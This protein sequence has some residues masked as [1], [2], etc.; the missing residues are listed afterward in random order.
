MNDAKQ[1]ANLPIRIGG[2]GLRSAVRCAGAAYW[3]SW[4][5]A[6]H[7]ISE[8]NPAVA[9]TVVESLA[10]LRMA[11]NRLDREGFWWRPSWANL[12]FRE[13][14]G[15]SSDENVLRPVETVCVSASGLSTAKST[16]RCRSV[17]MQRSPCSSR[18]YYMEHNKTELRGVEPR[19]K[20]RQRIQKSCENITVSKRVFM[21]ETVF[22]DI[23]I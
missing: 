9:D 5:D 21:S 8:R 13:G 23:W 1:M 14:R 10:E 20:A 16:T 4:A 12:R 3:A 19:G 2:L 6:L 22:G 17:L 15:R 11:T 18:T 7:M